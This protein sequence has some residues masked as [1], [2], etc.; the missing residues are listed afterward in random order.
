MPKTPLSFFDEMQLHAA[1]PNEANVRDIYAAY[2]H[3]LKD[4]PHHQLDS[5]RQEAE[6]LFR[7]VGITFNVYGETDG[8]ERL[9]PFD[10]IPRLLSAKEWSHLSTGAIQRVKALNMFLHYLP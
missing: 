4:V 3:W 8:A 9:I 10:V 2:H 1:N 6:L 7:R 5:K